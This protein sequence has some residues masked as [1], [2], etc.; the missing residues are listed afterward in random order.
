M[1]FFNNDGINLVGDKDTAPSKSYVFTSKEMEELQ[2][3]ISID[4]EHP[5]TIVYKENDNYS[6]I[7]SRLTWIKYRKECHVLRK[8]LNSSK[9][10]ECDIA[11]AKIMFAND[12][13]NISEEMKKLADKFYNDCHE[14]IQRPEFKKINGREYLEYD[15]PVLGFRELIF[16][17]KFNKQ[18]IGSFFVGQIDYNNIA[19]QK[20]LF[21]SKNNDDLKRS[22]LYGN[23]NNKIIRD[24]PISNK[25][26]FIEVNSNLLEEE[27][28][29]NKA[30]EDIDSDS[31]ISLRIKYGKSSAKFDTLCD[32]VL[33]ED[34]SEHILMR[35]PKSKKKYD[36]LIVRCSEHI[37]EI[38][39]RI[40]T[41][42]VDKTKHGIHNCVTDIIEDFYG[43]LNIFGQITIESRKMFWSD[44]VEK[45]LSN[46]KEQLDLRNIILFAESDNDLDTLNNVV[47]LEP[48]HN[49]NTISYFSLKK[50]SKSKSINIK[51]KTNSYINNS[52]FEC[53]DNEKYIGEE[54]KRKILIFF[55][56]SFSP[57][58]SIA[59]LICFKNDLSLIDQMVL[60]SFI[61]D[62][63]LLL[64]SIASVYAS[65]NDQIKTDEAKKLNAIYRHEVTHHIQ[66]IERISSMHFEDYAT[67]QD[68]SE[69]QV[70]NAY[71][72]MI[73]ILKRMLY[74]SQNTKFVYT[75]KIVKK[76]NLSAFY[77]FLYKFRSVYRAECTMQHKDIVV[78]PRENDDPLRQN[79]NTDINL[80]DLIV[81]NLVSNCVKYSFW[82][83][84]IYLDCAKP[85]I[86]STYSILSA[87]DYGIRL[88]ESKNPNKK[89][90]DLYYRSSEAQGT[91][92]T[93]FGIGLYVIKKLCDILRYEIKFT[94][95][96]V[97]NYNVP[98]LSLYI[99]RTRSRQMNRLYRHTHYYNEY[100][101]IKESGMLETIMINKERMYSSAK[102]KDSNIINGIDRPTFE[103]KCEVF[104]NE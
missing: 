23:E 35:S 25:N 21:L 58:K 48:I 78:K 26:F 11:H 34:I 104:I 98:L 32:I 83:T 20:A 87:T 43:R 5:A 66:A 49:D 46:L 24:I 84:N 12:T 92:S 74:I 47:Q 14:E 67:Y 15:C 97:S 2:N 95:T 70:K 37:S 65:I 50:M 36:A 51:N 6:R 62:I 3:T 89:I 38:E 18:T 77:N 56:L 82:G 9:C 61:E 40:Y 27:K 86:D 16:P 55:P 17:I 13:N 4:M 94:Q 19:K 60:K 102:R 69:K 59:I 90:F 7:D 72:D 57:T 53:L 30:L 103:V 79:I 71:S 42:L 31:E 81:N 64:A 52:L 44:I 73:G 68:K 88:Y 63:N 28:T 96:K 8:S 39:K 99:D 76:Q 45:I 22:F 93:G 85:T 33:E 29:L 54:K 10:I 75:D 91:D 101:K 80:F 41:K 1:L 100:K